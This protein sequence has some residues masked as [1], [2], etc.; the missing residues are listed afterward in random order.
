MKT[1]EKGETITTVEELLQQEFVFYNNKVTAKGWFLSW[2][3]R[4][5]VNAIN[6]GYLRKAIKIK[7]EVKNNVK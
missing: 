5:T 1:F 2:Q 4:M 6:R 3:L 7:T